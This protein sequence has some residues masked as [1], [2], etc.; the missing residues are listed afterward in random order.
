MNHRA[1]NAGSE[2]GDGS[3]TQ[4]SVAVFALALAACL[5]SALAQP[6]LTLDPS[7]GW[8]ATAPDESR[9]AD[10]QLMDRCRALLA[11]GNAKEA[12]SLLS[13]WLDENEF[14]TSPFLAEAYLLRGDARVATNSEWWALYDYEAVIKQFPASVEF[15]KAVEREFDIG[16]RYLT[17]L[18]TKIFWMRLED[19]TGLGAELL[20]RVQERLP[21]SRIAEEAC[22][23][24]A[25]HY[26][27][28]RDLTQASEMYDVFLHNFPT[29]EYRQRAMQRRAYAS[30]GQFKGPSYDAS[31]L[32]EAR[33][34]IKNF[35]EQ[36]PAE[37]ER[38][39]MSDALSARL[40][41]SIASQKLEKARWY[42]RQGDDVSARFTLNRLRR[43]HP[44]TVAASI[45]YDLMLEH[46][47]VK[48]KEA[49]PTIPADATPAQP[50]AGDAP[51]NDPKPEP[52]SDA[53][54]EGAK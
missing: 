22:L 24:L 41:E 53:K 43:S 12:R 7:Q 45:A 13:D 44:R 2:H 38:A 29:S 33:S 49:T 37:A 54:K 31:G 11:E 16:K 26:Y 6:D 28:V 9:P 30:I 34:L 23:F 48:E 46:G 14:S 19:A 4:R 50:A 8:M 15:P 5:N 51:K 17:G 10:G 18:K 32:V 35:A 52:A 3:L 25:D 27:Q 47:W 42:F 39:G 36:Y 20:V 21:G 1:T 40:D